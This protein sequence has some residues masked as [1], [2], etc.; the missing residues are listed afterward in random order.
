[1]SQIPD[2]ELIRKCQQG[3]KASFGI[4]VGR[5]KDN[6]YNTVFRTLGNQHDA[7]DIAQEAFISAYKAI[8]KF[9]PE[10]A[11]M[12]WLLKIAVNLSIDYL[13]RKQMQTVS[14]D[15][16]E[17]QSSGNLDPVKN[18]LHSNSD[19]VEELEL[20]QTVEQLLSVLP[21]KYRAVIVLYYT[22]GLKYNEIAQTLDIPV[23]TVKT[24]LHRGR[25][26]LK[27]QAKTALR[28]SVEI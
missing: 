19:G 24:Y 3:N 28:D 27:E 9:D 22:E 25:Y 4:L 6:V 17:M 21:P 12:P 23:G 13:R 14:L 26:I 20:Q 11:F 7:E 1:M 2:K 5:Y 8:G 16:I 10:R 15:S 18:K